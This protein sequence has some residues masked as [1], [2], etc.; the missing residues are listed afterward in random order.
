MLG[1][2]AT[3]AASLS[4]HAQNSPLASTILPVTLTYFPS[5]RAQRQ[6]EAVLVAPRLKGMHVPWAVGTACPLA[7]A[8]Y[9]CA[10]SPQSPGVVA[11]WRL[12]EGW[13]LWSGGWPFSAQTLSSL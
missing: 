12:V 8:P 3:L 11:A 1:S 10:R 7:T 2:L 9:A 13:W 6:S 5:P 4:L